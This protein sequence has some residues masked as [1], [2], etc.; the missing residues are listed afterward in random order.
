MR[1]DRKLN[2][3]QLPNGGLSKLICPVLTPPVW[4]R[5]PLP[6]EMLPFPP[7][8][9]E[10]FTWTTSLPIKEK[11]LSLT[12]VLLS[13]DKERPSAPACWMVFSLKNELFESLTAMAF[14]SPHHVDVPR[15]DRQWLEQRVQIR[16]V[17]KRR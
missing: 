10:L 5:L 13:F 7:R 8:L 1:I 9:V 2:Y 11:L 17:E 12:L 3:G 4:Q 15:L 14:A 6:S 16:T